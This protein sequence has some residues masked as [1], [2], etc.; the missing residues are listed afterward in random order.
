VRAVGASSPPAL[1]RPLSSAIIEGS[2][3]GPRSAAGSSSLPA[4]TAP[5]GGPPA[6][7]ALASAFAR[8]QAWMATPAVPR[9]S[10]SAGQAA[11]PGQIG[12]IEQGAGVEAALPPPR[13][14]ATPRPLGRASEPPSLVTASFEGQDQRGGNG[15]SVPAAAVVTEAS[16]G[17][18]IGHLSVQVLPPPAPPAAPRERAARSQRRPEGAGFEGGARQRGLVARLGFGMRH[19]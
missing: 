19:W 1:S 6:V 16:R 13:A 17:L 4:E 5:A 9:S 11:T 2:V 3:A 7:A 18:E 12:A 14:V 15:G 8:L 10:G